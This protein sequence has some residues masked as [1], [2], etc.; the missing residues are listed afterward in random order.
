MGLASLKCQSGYSFKTLK[1]KAIMG[2]ILDGVSAGRP[3]LTKFSAHRKLISSFAQARVSNSGLKL[4]RATKASLRISAQSGGRQT[5]SKVVW[6]PRGRLQSEFGG[7]Y[8]D[9]RVFLA[10]AML[11]LESFWGR[12]VLARYTDSPVI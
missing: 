12:V 8:R 7:R 11:T 6:R 4:E 9:S 1:S 5:D 2:K 10:A 3:K